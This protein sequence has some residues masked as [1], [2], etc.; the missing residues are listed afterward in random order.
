M[1][2][3]TIAILF[4]LSV[5]Y[6]QAQ[7]VIKD[8]ADLLKLKKVPQE[9]AYIDHNGP[10]LLSG[11]YLYYSVH[12]FNAQTNKLTDVSKIGYVALVNESKQFIFEHKIKLAKGHGAGDFFVTTEIPSGKYKLLG[13][14]Q[15]MKNAGLSQVFK[16]DI[17]VINPYLA[18]QTALLPMSNTHLEN[19]VD[20]KETKKSIDS[21]T[22]ALS[23]NK[24]TYQTREKV[25][26]T[27]KNYKGPLGYGTY[28]IKVKKI[29][30]LNSTPA[31]EATT[32]A[33]NYFNAN[34]QITQAVGDS[35]FLPEQRGELFFGKVVDKETKVPVPNIPV[36]ISIPGKEFLLKFSQTDDKGNFYS[37]FI[38]DHK[39]AMAIVQIE[40]Q[41]KSYTVEKSSTR[42]L[43]LTGL[44]FSDF[45][46]TEKMAQSI[47]DR[48]IANQIENQFFTAKPDSIL[49]SDPIDPFDGGI[50]EVVL[51]EEYTRFPTFEETLKE[52]V[53][54]SG[55]RKNDQVKDYIKVSQDFKDYNEQYNDFPAIV[56]VD[57]VFIPQHSEIRNMDART[58]EKIS[59]IRDQFR[60]GQKDYQGIVSI[61][62]FKGD[63]VEGYSAPNSTVVPFE[64]PVSKKNYF[65]QKYLTEDTSYER[66]PDYRNL[67]FWQPQLK[68]NEST[69]EF[70][71]YTSDLDGDFEITLNGFTSYGKPLTVSK[72]ITVVAQQLD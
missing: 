49:A 16:D 13:Y 8:G 18:D 21:A 35:I 38:K 5:F 64:R 11:E 70:E 63:Y 51:L 30:E 23:T 57:G 65:V 17:I 50:P 31:L 56:L 46:L 42:K 60:L 44:S 2:I 3:K 33:T 12:F 36:V 15:W 9:K 27:I 68:I 37:Y 41:D 29:D 7:Y 54:Y 62:T 14:T 25:G 61:E 28:S 32:Y 48:S 1:K 45:V 71:F 6:A 4:L 40:N 43:D 34:K 20:E 72:K 66:I 22:I 47:K 53:E 39:H 10:I 52:V 58:I 24:S 55:Y 69:Y 19:Y 26:L 59:L 67:L